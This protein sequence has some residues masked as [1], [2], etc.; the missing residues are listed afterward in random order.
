MDRPPGSNPGS[1]AFV[2]S[3]PSEDETK[4][5]TGVDL[6]C[7]R[8]YHSVFT[9]LDVSAAIAP[10]LNCGLPEGVSYITAS[11]DVKQQSWVHQILQQYCDER[12]ISSFQFNNAGT[13]T[14]TK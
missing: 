14:I 3:S 8:F 6:A 9:E 11:D 12:K 7:A 13:L 1:L 5:R 10:Y 2:H 4:E